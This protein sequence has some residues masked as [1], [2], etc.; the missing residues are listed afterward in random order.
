[1]CRHKFWSILLLLVLCGTQFACG[2][3][4]QQKTTSL[5]VQTKAIPSQNVKAA[6]PSRFNEETKQSESVRVLFRKKDLLMVA[7]DGSLFVLYLDEAVKESSN[8]MKKSLSPTNRCTFIEVSQDD[9]CEIASSGVKAT[10][11]PWSLDPKDFDFLVTWEIVWDE[12]TKLNIFSD[13]IITV[14][15]TWRVQKV[16]SPDLSRSWSCEYILD[17]G[18]TMSEEESLRLARNQCETVIAPNRGP[19]LESLCSFIEGNR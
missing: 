6:S 19:I 1:M 16:S 13:L 5:A 2:K 11:R 7:L 9:V 8:K 14:K 3:S 10:P 15:E 18:K 17:G 4:E 12:H